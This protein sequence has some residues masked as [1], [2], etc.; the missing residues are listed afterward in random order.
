MGKNTIWKEF[1]VD[2]L[3]ERTTPPSTGV[4]AKQL[5]V[6]EEQSDGLIALITRGKSNNGIV[7]YIEKGDFETKK[8]KITYNDQFGL[9]LYHPYEFT[10]IKDHLSVL[11]AKTDAL[12]KI[13]DS[14]ANANIFI[15]K[16][17]DRA[18]SKKIFSFNYSPS[19]FRFGR[20]LIL[21]PLVENNDIQFEICKINGQSYT[22]DTDTIDNL[23]LETRKRINER[24]I[25]FYKSKE[26]EFKELTK[27]Y[28][29]LKHDASDIVWIPFNL[30]DLFDRDTSLALN[31]NQKDI[32]LSDTKD[33]EHSVAL[34]SASSVGSGCVGFLENSDYEDSKVSNGK[35]TFDDQWGYTYFQNQDFIITGGH[36]AILELKNAYIKKQ[37]DTDANLYRFVSD[38][39]NKVTIKSEIFGFGYKINNKLDREII[40]LP[41]IETQNGDSYEHNGKHYELAKNDMLFMYSSGKV[42]LYQ[43]M[44][45]SHKSYI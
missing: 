40:L 13:L 6:Y 37:L 42:K 33:N 14:S 20:E 27:Q 34:I 1:S 2:S 18:L 44:I 36:N 23:L 35:I 38:L 26:K 45:A 31:K 16:M 19:D 25:D 39:I 4:P 41:F 9:V 32:N 29:N 10:T 30:G 7:G 3:L 11:E 17:I 12:R 22:L 5:T 24:T 8:N 28:Q 21:L 15:A 43:Q